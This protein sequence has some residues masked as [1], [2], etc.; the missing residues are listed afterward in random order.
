MKRI[1]AMMLA[2]LLVAVAAGC[3]GSKGSTSGPSGLKEVKVATVSPLSGGQASLGVAIKNGAELAIKDREK[4]LTAAG[5]K[6]VFQPQD[7]EAK[8]EVGTQ[9]AQRLAA[10]KGFLGVVGTLNT[11]VAKGIA[12]ILLREGGGLVMV[13]PANTGVVMTESGWT[14]YNRIVFRDDYQGPAAARYAAQVLKIKTAYVMHD[15][16]DYGKALADEFAKEVQKQGVTVAAT[17]GVDEKKADYGPEATQ[18][19]AKNPDLIYFGGIY[20]TAGPLFKQM[21]AKGFKGAF[22]GGDGLDSADLVKLGGDA[23]DNTY[24]TSVSADYKTGEGK[25]FYDKYKAA[26]KDEPAAYALYGYDSMNVILQTLI[27]YGKKNSG[28]VPGREEFAKLVRATKNFKAISSTVSF[29]EK[30]DNPTSKV[31]VFKIDKGK[32]VDLGAAPE[33]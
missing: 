25:A 6:V 30:G 33:K 2:V 27:D 14:N 1:L 17:V 22:L 5:Y 12:P 31:F 10:D 26:Y 9:I 13:S 16:T 21:R 20:D 3:G 4:D 19:V 32:S 11:G 24:F 29:N 18:A 28:K 23:V 15:K 8:P 7:D